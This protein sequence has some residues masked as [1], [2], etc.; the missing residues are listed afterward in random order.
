MLGPAVLAHVDL[1][2]TRDVGFLPRRAAPDVAVCEE[3]DEPVR[4]GAVE[5]PEL[6][7]ISDLVPSRANP[8]LL[9]ALE[10]SGAG[11]VLWALDETGATIGSLTVDGV[12]AVD[13]EDLAIAPCEGDPARPCIWV[14][15]VGDNG[16]SRA[17]ARVLAVE[18]PRVTGAFALHAPATEY[19]FR[20]PDGAANVEGL[21]I[22]PDGLPLL[23]TKRVDATAELWRF[24]S[25]DAGRTV[26]VEKVGD[27][28]TGD[29]ADEHPAEATSAEL[30]ADGSRL[31]VRTYGFLWDFPVEGGRAGSGVALPAPEEPQGESA[32]WDE[33]EGGVWLT[34]EGVGQ[35]IWFVGCLR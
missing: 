15:D 20:Y 34:S 31:L 8:G 16:L 33:R 4:T 27:V 6:D 29:P 2:P 3:W 17:D 25:L 24:P 11:P 28:V 26:T 14:G 13:W 19:P 1:R 5:D 35:P 23:V 30:T 21:A 22:G 12:D 10:D 32:A 18:E 7:E 9:W